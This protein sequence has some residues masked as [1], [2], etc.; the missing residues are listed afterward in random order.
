MNTSIPTITNQLNFVSFTIITLSLLFSTSCSRNN[1]RNIQINSSVVSENQFDINKSKIYKQLNADSYKCIIIQNDECFLVTKN[2]KVIPTSRHHYYSYDDSDPNL[3]LT[4]DK[5]IY[6]EYFIFNL[7]G[8]FHF[9]DT[10]GLDLIPETFY[11]YKFYPLSSDDDIVFG[12]TEKG[13]NA[14]DLRFPDH[15]RF[16]KFYF[17]ECRETN[18]GMILLDSNGDVYRVFT[19]EGWLMTMNLSEEERNQQEEQE[20]I[21]KNLQL[22]QMV[23]L[24]QQYQQSQLNNAY[25]YYENYNISF[26]DNNKIKAEI[27]E[28]KKRIE[29]CES[30]MNDGIA[31]G[32]GYRSI[33]SSYEDMIRN[34]QMEMR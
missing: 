13:W 20:R 7:N 3:D 18:D 28:Y 16:Y 11:D 17:T 34:R 19:D 22:L 21:K 6:N 32:I 5:G 10:D 26:R 27:D 31:E 30:H 14:Y 25:N 23:F 1:K 8:K 12:K 33:I 2:D 9:I 29:F 24:C 4:T 15:S